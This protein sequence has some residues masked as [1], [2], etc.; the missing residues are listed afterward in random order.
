MAIR[1]ILNKTKRRRQK[2]Q[3]VDSAK[4]I[5]MGIGIGAALGSALGVLFAPK[6]GQETRQDIVDT[7]KDAVENIKENTSEV[8]EKISQIVEE[9]RERI[10]A[11]KADI[12][13]EDEVAAEGEKCSD[14]IESCCGG[15]EELVAEYEDTDDKENNDIE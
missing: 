4:K 13:V 6:S 15:C 10:A 3:T 2:A 1:E 5:G 9:G 12:D 7:A 8:G 11:I 14:D